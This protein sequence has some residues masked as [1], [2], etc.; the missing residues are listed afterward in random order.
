LRFV[1]E[2]FGVDDQNP[3]SSRKANPS[4]IGGLEAFWPSVGNTPTAR[5]KQSCFLES[6]RMHD[7]VVPKD[8]ALRLR[9]FLLDT[10]DQTEGLGCLDVKESDDLI[11]LRVAW[12]TLFEIRSLESIEDR[13]CELSI[14]CAVDR[15]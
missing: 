3:C 4:S 5:L 10:S 2:L 14:R 6:N 11:A 1:L 8:I 9:G 15:C 13:C 12:G 7:L